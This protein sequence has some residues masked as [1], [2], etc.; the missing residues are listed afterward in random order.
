[1]SCLALN[2][3]CSRLLAGFARGLLLMIDTNDGKVLRTMTDVHTPATAV[4]HVKVCVFEYR[5]LSGQQKHW[6]G[7]AYVLFL[8]YV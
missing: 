7:K 8:I 3:D 4:L 6:L 1:M 2:P 5:E